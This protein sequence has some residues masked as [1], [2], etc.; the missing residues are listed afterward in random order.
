MKVLGISGSM[1]KNG[2]TAALVKE[3]LGRCEAANIPTEYISL[4][5][6]EIKP[7]IGCEKCKEKKWC[8]I[9]KDDWGEIIEKV[10][11]S[12]CVNRLSH[13]FLRCLCH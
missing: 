12:M 5:G 2:N 11:D 1:R 4:A 9:E 6:K 3:V 13:V 7:C 8:V 10:M